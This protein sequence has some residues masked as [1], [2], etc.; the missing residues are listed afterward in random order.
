VAHA[1]AAGA[2]A[3]VI[4]DDVYEPLILMAKVGGWVGGLGVRWK[5]RE[6][7]RLCAC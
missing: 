3:A 5:A 6:G 1:E 4:Y 7:R 2:V